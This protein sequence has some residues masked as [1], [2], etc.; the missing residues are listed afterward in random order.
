M[1]ITTFSSLLTRSDIRSVGQAL[2]L[3]TEKILLLSLHQFDTEASFCSKIRYN[4]SEH[5]PSSWMGSLFS[6]NASLHS[7]SFLKHADP[8]LHMLLIQMDLEEA[9]CSDELISSAK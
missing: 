5:L 8:S 4:L 6:S 7:R 3:D 1:Q 9:Q 2:Q